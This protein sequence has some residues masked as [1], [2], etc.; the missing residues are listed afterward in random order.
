MSLNTLLMSVQMLKE[1]TSIHGNLDEKLVY[2]DIKYVQDTYI[3]P[4]LGTALFSKLQ[5]IV[6]NNTVGESGNVNYKFLLDTYIIDA[7]V[8]FTFAELQLTTSFQLWNKG[9]LRKGGLDTETPSM[10]EIV[11][12][13]NRYK[14][15]AESYIER[16]RQYI[17]ANAQTMYPEYLNPGNTI[18]TVNP[19]QKAFTSPIYL[20][21]DDDRYC[22]HPQP[23]QP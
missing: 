18:D 19:G 14:N 1:R 5:T 11:D 20:G 13:Q 4:M 9:V 8:Y 22:D 23:Y 2:P 12:L 10:G 17:R 3:L 16:M 21:G 6:G 7:M 15:R